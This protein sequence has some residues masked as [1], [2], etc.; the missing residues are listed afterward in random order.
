MPE[1]VSRTRTF[2]KSLGKP[3]LI[4]V[5]ALVLAGLCGFLTATALGVGNQQEAGTV[6]INLATGPT[7]PAGPQG[8]K[9]EQGDPGP[10]G[11]QGLQGPKG[12]QGERGPQG[13]KGEPGPQGSKGDP[14]EVAC[15]TGF[16]NSNLVINHPG[17]QVTLHTCI[18]D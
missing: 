5:G 9:G 2:L 14:G 15:P 16:S 4:S 11:E 18:K 1:F 12:D 8:P 13:L 6:T 17:G 10:K 3:F 7:G